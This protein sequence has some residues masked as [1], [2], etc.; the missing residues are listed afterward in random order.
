M[1]IGDA[2]SFEVGGWRVTPDEH[3]LSR[4]GRR[5]RLEPLAMRV[6]VYLAARAGEV[7]SRSEPE[8]AVWKGGVVS[9]DAVTSTVIKL[10]KA[11]GDDARRPAYIATIPK[12]G[13]QLIAPVSAA[14]EQEAATP[15][16]VPENQ[17]HEST[18]KRRLAAILMADMVDYSRRLET[19]EA[20]T[21]GVFKACVVDIFNPSIQRHGGRTVRLTGD[22]A[23]VE[24]PSA[25]EATQCAIDIQR[26]IAECNASRTESEPV[27][28]RMGISIG[29]IVEDADNLHGSGINIAARLEGQCKPG[30]ILLSEEAAA[31]VEGRVDAALQYLGEQ[32]LKNIERKIRVWS[33][34]PA[35]SSVT[36]PPRR[37]T[38]RVRPMFLAVTSLA[39]FAAVIAWLI[40]FRTQGPGQSGVVPAARLSPVTHATPALAV[41]PFE[42][43]GSDTQQN[44]LGD[45]IA[46]D[47]IT[48][49]SRLR[50][51]TVIARSS[52]FRY[53]GKSPK[54]QDVHLDLG[55]SHLLEGSV[56]RAGDRLRIAVQLID[57]TTGHQLWAERYDRVLDDVFA[58]QSEI[59]RKIAAQLSVELAGSESEQLRGQRASSFAA[60]D[61]FLKGMQAHLQYTRESNE[62]GQSYYREA[63]V[64]D[65]AFGRAYGALAVSLARGAA[66]GWYEN[67]TKI[68]EEALRLAR[69]A[70]ELD[71]Y[72]PQTHWAL[73]YV[74]YTR[75]EAEAAISAVRRS[76]ELAPNYADGYGML[77]LISNSL[78]KAEDAIAYVKRGMV[79]NPFYSWDYKYNLG[80]AL[81]IKGDYADAVIEL[82]DALERNSTP[83]FPRVFLTASLVRLNRVDDAEWQVMQLETDHPELTV[84]SL[85]KYMPISEGPH[86][87]QL[88]Q[89]L[90]AA[91]MGE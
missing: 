28:F 42:D 31:Q 86:K 39:M 59:A 51:L 21:I 16:Q 63:V 22:G 57:A 17:P 61:L 45:G 9:Y 32:R 81:Y 13:Y 85:E 87:S 89:D 41:L 11:L 75:G 65:P 43:L 48:D 73:G 47:L 64:L 5:E 36:A 38:V 52:S 14:G 18:A 62:Q 37:R 68:L 83:M 44:Y 77:A 78:G 24:F 49:L 70:V 58:I 50:N 7:V 1:G 35:P 82:Q 33:V 27:A 26:G 6:L 60:Y 56:R 8:E 71:P 54:A 67:A 69:T 40:P 25:V 66:S 53:R 88:L 46:E 12:R 79:L 23:L 29:D 76:V 30:R 80:R 84:S 74:Y 72:A 3:T 34:D 10:R 20:G 4:D 15:V 55:V 91:G 19:N 2:K 90:R